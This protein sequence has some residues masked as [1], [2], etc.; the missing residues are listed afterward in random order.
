MQKWPDKLFTVTLL[1]RKIRDVAGVQSDAPRRGATGLLHHV[2]GV[3]RGA[4]VSH[5]TQEGEGSLRIP[6]QG[7]SCKSH[8][9][10]IHRGH[11]STEFKTEI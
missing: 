3:D 2:H 9:I 7:K 11:L 1:L 6:Y 4:E 8:V 10:L 5:H